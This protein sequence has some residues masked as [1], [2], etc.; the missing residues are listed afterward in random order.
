MQGSKVTHTRRTTS[1][2]WSVNKRLCLRVCIGRVTK[3]FGFLVLG[4]ICYRLQVIA[5][6]VFSLIPDVARGGPLSSW[7]WEVPGFT[8]L[9]GLESTTVT[10]P[11]ESFPSD[12]AFQKY[13]D[14]PIARIHC[15][16]ETFNETR[17]HTPAALYRS[18]HYENMCYH[19]QE[20][21]LVL[22]PSPHHWTLLSKL[23]DN[24]HLSSVSKPVIASAVRKLVTDSTAQITP[25]YMHPRNGNNNNSFYY[26]RN[27]TK[28]VLVPIQPE[29]C[30]SILWDV[31]LP[32]YTLLEQFDLQHE[33]YRLLLLGE[34]ASNCTRHKMDAFA[35]MMGFATSDIVS[36]H[37]TNSTT[38]GREEN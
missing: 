28:V 1:E 17:T 16:G 10:L 13:T 36:F 12:N 37:G 18:C 25:Y 33:P 31:Y 22:F 34:P 32:V 29:S 26:V 5:S 21:R 9:D 7:Q 3:P 15:L 30:Q 20:K 8:T 24:I 4:A 35:T 19:I 38:G 2:S 6:T 27:D 11:G 14:P 23:H